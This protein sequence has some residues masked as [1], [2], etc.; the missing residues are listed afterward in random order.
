MDIEN[1]VEKHEFLYYFGPPYKTM[2]NFMTLKTG[3]I[4]IA[5]TD[6]ILSL[7]GLIEMIGFIFT[8]TSDDKIVATIYFYSMLALLDI[9][10]L[11]L[12]LIGLKG[13][14]KLSQKEISIYSQFKIIEFFIIAFLKFLLI[15]FDEDTETISII[16][17]CL[18]II[19][20]RLIA[21]FL[22]K[23]VWS[24]DI[25]LKHNETILVIHGEEALKLMQ[26]QAINLSDSS[27][28]SSS[29][30]PYISPSYNR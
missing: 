19:F 5:I 7:Y 23:I 16:W 12:A 6:I 18:F 26:Q 22:V 21:F 14:N 15:K 17:E 28:W 3:V 9:I 10:A 27:S 1:E 2:C 13:I 8:L 24:A 20:Q 11:P 4:L 30:P 25:R 29:V